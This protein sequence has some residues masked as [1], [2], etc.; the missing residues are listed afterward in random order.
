MQFCNFTLQRF[1]LLTN[2]N[3]TNKGILINL[4]HHHH[5]HHKLNTLTESD[6]LCDAMRID[7]LA[8][9][10]SLLT[11]YASK[12]RKWPEETSWCR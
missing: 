4:H 6:I 11:E 1:F 10:R 7:L 5:H 9:M 3:T 2:I 8:T 12:R